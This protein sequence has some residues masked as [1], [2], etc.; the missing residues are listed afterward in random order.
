M[1]PSPR[2]YILGCPRSGT[3]FV[4][5]LLNAHPDLHVSFWEAQFPLLLI[6]RTREPGPLESEPET[7]LELDQ[8]LV[9]HGIDVPAR[10]GERTLDRVA[11]GRILR[12]WREGGT[13]AER[14]DRAAAR[15]WEERGPGAGDKV[16][17]FTFIADDLRDLHPGAFRI[18]VRRNLQETAASM[19]AVA[20]RNHHVFC[21]PDPRCAALVWLRREEQRLRY[22]PRPDRDLAVDYDEFCARPAERSR[23]L[24]RALGL[25]PTPQTEA[26]VASR[27]RTP[28]RRGPVDP[29]LDAF[30]ARVRKE[31]LP[32]DVP[33]DLMAVDAQYAADPITLL[34]HAVERDAGCFRALTGL[35]EAHWRGGDADSAARWAE[36]AC[37][38]GAADPVLRRPAGK[39]ALLRAWAARVVGDV[40]GAREWT[41]R[42]LELFPEYGLARRYL[43]EILNACP[44]RE[45]AF[46]G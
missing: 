7:T 10:H 45:G 4:A 34:D 28:V 15:Y 26:F 23:D 33:A 42:S 44:P 32:A 8:A 3:T 11:V 38:R 31:G 18:W 36:A 5:E 2:V 37:I 12:A 41:K 9:W 14:R 1:L 35:A 25:K 20:R 22:V 46:I 21:A 13:P 29:G 17:D 19:L 40:A 30:T 27:F 39:A 16:P 43:D 24:L 6:R